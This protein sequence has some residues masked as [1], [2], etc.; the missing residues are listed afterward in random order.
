MV[1]AA[2]IGIAY[3]AKA[4]LKSATPH[5]IDFTPL[6]SLVHFANVPVPESIKAEKNEEKARLETLPLSEGLPSFTS[7]V[8][9]FNLL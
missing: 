2:G 9:L 7:I 4:I 8:D 6:N 5:H 3:H 1:R